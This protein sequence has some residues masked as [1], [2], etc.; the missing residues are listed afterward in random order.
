MRL[1]MVNAYAHV[2][3]GADRHCLALA[4][5]LRAHGH[6]VAFLST[7]SDKNVEHEGAF[8]G[9]T[10][11]HQSRDTLRPLERGRAAVRAIWNREAAGA[12]RALIR[13]YKPD[14]VHAHKLYPQLSVAPLVEAGRFGIPVVQ[15]LHDYELAAASSTDDRGGWFDRDESRLQYRLLNDATYVVRRT[16]HRRQVTAWVAISRFVE[17]VYERA[18]IHSR[19]LPNFTEAPACPPPPIDVRRGALYAGR[20]TESKGVRDVLLLADDLPEIPVTI[21]GDGPL[22]EAVKKAANRLPNLAYIGSVSPEKVTELLRRARVLLMPSRWQE[23]GGLSALEA[24]AVGTPVVAFDVGGLSEYV[25]DAGGGVTVEVNTA[26]LTQACRLLINDHQIWR[27]YSEQGM[28][29]V[30]EAHSPAHYG[31]ELETVYRTALDAAQ[32]RPA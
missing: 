15:T 17:G 28:T 1:V 19:V 2:T 12:M 6:Q 20:L 4:D 5:E 10:V 18:G 30:A 9:L 31:S 27:G 8:V 13:S 25:D 14:L 23:P 11:S 16:V 21:A 26:A 7:A 32:R 22:R 24:M 29:S 3:G